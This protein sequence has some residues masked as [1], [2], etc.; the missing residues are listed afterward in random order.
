MRKEIIGIFLDTT[1]HRESHPPV[2]ANS[3]P[4]ARAAR[5]APRL[6]AM[7]ICSLKWLK[8]EGDSQMVE[9]RR[10]AMKE[11]SAPLRA[12]RKLGRGLDL[13]AFFDLGRR[14]VEDCGVVRVLFF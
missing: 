13:R 9:T 7:P 6:S 2:A 4:S 1:M 3:T 5:P 12:R 8:V 14:A 10:M 11:E